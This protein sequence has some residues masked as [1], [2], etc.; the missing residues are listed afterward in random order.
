[1]KQICFCILIV[2]MVVQP[3]FGQIKFERHVLPQ[4]PSSFSV[5]HPLK[6]GGY[7]LVGGI[8]IGKGLSGYPAT[9]CVART[10]AQGKILPNVF[11]KDFNTLIDVIDI[12][13]ISKY[14]YLILGRWSFDSKSFLM[15]MN[16][17]GGQVTLGKM[18]ILEHT[19]HRITKTSDKRV[20]LTGETIRDLLVMKQNLQGETLWQK[21]YT[22]F[23]RINAATGHEALQVNDG[24]LIAGSVGK[25]NQKEYGVHKISLKG[26]S[27][28]TRYYSLHYGEAKVIKAA[29]RRGQYLVGGQYAGGNRAKKAAFLVKINSI[30]DTLWARRMGEDKGD[31]LVDICVNKKNEYVVLVNTEIYTYYKKRTVMGCYVFNENGHLLRKRFF[32]ATGS[33]ECYAQ[34]M[35]LDKQGNIIL[36]VRV[37]VDQTY[38]TFLMKVKP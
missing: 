22:A 13:Q 15:K 18:Q 31:K 21:T 8:L 29:Q 24:F 6:K 38:T 10:D 1:M 19:I 3:S 25:R 7:L 17:K 20:L 32:R 37:K 35:L 12:V 11:Y 9:L 34:N 16:L 26:D 27:L 2:L 23:D 33:D 4:K 36:L 5:I 30:G 14:Q 28:W